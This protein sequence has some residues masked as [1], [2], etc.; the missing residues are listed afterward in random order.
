MMCAGT[1]VQF[2]IP[3]VMVGEHDTF[4]GN[5]DFLRAHGVEVLVLDDPR[6]MDLMRRFQALSRGLAGGFASRHPDP[7]SPSCGAA[8]AG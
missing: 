7:P 3:R 6:C 5:G 1:I 2:G 8:T 4:P